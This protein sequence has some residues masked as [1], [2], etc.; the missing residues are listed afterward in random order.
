[1]G[2]REELGYPNLIEDAGHEAVLNVVVTGA[3]LAKEG[4]ALLRPHGVTEAQFNVLM[5]LRYQS[6]PEGSPQTAL[7]RML[8]VNRSNVTGIVDRMEAAG[9]VERLPEPGDRRV[10]LVRLTAR[11]RKIT[12]RACEAYISRISEVTAGLSAAD[13]QTLC[14]LLE[15]I[16]RGLAP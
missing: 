14:R 6:P 16:R 11:G 9:W 12:D 13:R 5:L 8:V 15:R 1:M 4:D 7:G 3:M 10:N 2:L